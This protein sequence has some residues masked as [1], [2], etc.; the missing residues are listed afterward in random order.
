MNTDP[1]VREWEDRM[2]LVQEWEDRM[3][4]A[5]EWEDHIDR[6]DCGDRHR[7]HTEAAAEAAVLCRLLYL[8]AL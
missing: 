2:D 5:Q 4:L 7:R 1:E 3:D 6:A 8:Q